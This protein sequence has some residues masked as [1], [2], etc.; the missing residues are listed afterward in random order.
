MYSCYLHIP[1]SR[2]GLLPHNFTIVKE[3]VEKVQIYY[4]FDGRGYKSNSYKS[5]N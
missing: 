4:F 5:Q 1:K 3:T 2:V